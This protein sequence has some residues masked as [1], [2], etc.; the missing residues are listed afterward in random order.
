MSKTCRLIALSLFCLPAAPFYES[1]AHAGVGSCRK[2]FKPEYAVHYGIDEAAWKE[3]C[4]AYV[5]ETDILSMAAY[6]CAS[7]YE[8]R[9]M[10]SVGVS[11]DAW[12]AF[13]GDQSSAVS[14]EDFLTHN[15]KI[16][17]MER[18]SREISMEAAS[19]FMESTSNDKSAPVKAKRKELAPMLKK[20]CA[21]EKR[22]GRSLAQVP[23]TT[24]ANSLEDALL[25]LSSSFDGSAHQAE[26]PADAVEAPAASPAKNGL[27]PAKK[28]AP[29]DP[30]A[31]YAQTL[32]T[33]LRADIDKLEAAQTSANKPL[34]DPQTISSLRLIADYIASSPRPNPAALSDAGRVVEALN[35]RGVTVE[36]KDL[37]SRDEN[38]IHDPIR[39]AFISRLNMDGKPHSPEQLAGLLLHGV[40]GHAHAFS[41]GG[42]LNMMANE[43]DAWFMQYRFYA[44]VHRALDAKARELQKDLKK[45]R[46]K[47]AQLAA[48]K[49]EL[50]ETLD[51]RDR[52]LET[53]YA[54]DLKRFEKDPAAFI[55]TVL[56]PYYGEEIFPGAATPGQQ[57]E[58]LCQERG[59]GWHR[60]ANAALSLVGVR[61]KPAEIEKQ[62][63]VLEQDETLERER[64][65]LDLQWRRLMREECLL[66]KAE[67]PAAAAKSAVCGIR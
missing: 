34:H 25:K 66:L 19:L 17:V 60:Y 67:N 5:D 1:P 65:R 18:P 11:S 9:F 24:P 15:L 13:C 36:W 35:L 6:S 30:D 63:K 4:N 23:V 46:L 58:L 41:E 57:R 49:K 33:N 50:A 27:E 62:M 53:A 7:R 45:G 8:P 31:Q 3:Q 56:K 47:A 38:Y 55:R 26:A 14:E 44:D 2:S 20:L 29:K 52:F 28:R 54:A 12:K 59:E 64:L 39:K 42:G 43:L 21:A 37:S 51:K 10:A 40:G 16:F 48:R 22:L 32:L 61:M